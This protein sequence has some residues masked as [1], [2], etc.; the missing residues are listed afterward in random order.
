MREGVSPTEPMVQDPEGLN[1][2]GVDDEGTEKDDE[3]H[4]SEEHEGLERGED[5]FDHVDPE[6]TLVKTYVS[7]MK[8]SREEVERHNVTVG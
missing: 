5:V 6:E 7:P 8:P 1:P 4:D 3:E 2:G